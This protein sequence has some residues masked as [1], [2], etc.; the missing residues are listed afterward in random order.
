MKRRYL[1]WLALSLLGVALLLYLCILAGLPAWLLAR[2]LSAELRQPV[3]LAKNPQITLNFQHV[4]ITLRGLQVGR[5][6]LVL[7]QTRVDWAWTALRAGRWLDLELRVDGLDLHGPWPTTGPSSGQGLVL[8]QRLIVRDSSVRWPLGKQM[9]QVSGLQADYRAGQGAMMAGQLSYAGRTMTMQA[10][11]RSPQP[12][13]AGA[14]SLLVQAQKEVLSLQAEGVTAPATGTLAIAR[15]MLRLVGKPIDGELR[16]QGLRYAADAHSLAI[17]SWRI[18][19]H[20]QLLGQGNLL[21]HWQRAFGISGQ[22]ELQSE[23]LPDWLRLLGLSVP[24][25]REGEALRPAALSGNLAW[26]QDGP[27]QLD[28]LRGILGKTQ[29]QGSLLRDNAEAP[30][31]VTA[32]IPRLD[33]DPWLPPAPARAPSQKVLP[34]LPK[35]WP[36][37][38]GQVRIGELRWGRWQARNLQIRLRAKSK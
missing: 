24:K 27:I 10:R 12:R 22:F 37:I 17:R 20:P 16:W 5:R 31:Q 13:R 11:Y 3:T 4:G 9:L 8:P 19:A 15:G 23:N 14:I 35:S 30:W 36:P 29:F 7:R 26:T 18:T 38:H 2:L 28:P 25:I 34:T 6:L 32:V 1:L 33:L 21:L